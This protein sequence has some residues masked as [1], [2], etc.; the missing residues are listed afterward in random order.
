MEF[1]VL[2]MYVATLKIWQLKKVIV[3]LRFYGANSVLYPN[4]NV[5][6]RTEYPNSQIGSLDSE[7]GIDQTP[8]QREKQTDRRSRLLSR[9]SGPRYKRI[10]KKWRRYRYPEAVSSVKQII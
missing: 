7:A 8:A 10:I 5:G 2:Y 1:A 4:V 9:L 6:T 3:N